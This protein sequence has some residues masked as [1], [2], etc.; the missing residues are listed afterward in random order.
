MEKRMT[1]QQIELLL[2]TLEKRLIHLEEIVYGHSASPPT[3][4]VKNVAVGGQELLLALANDELPAAIPSG[5]EIGSAPHQPVTGTGNG[6][7]FRD[8]EKYLAWTGDKR[9]P[10]KEPVEPAT[11]KPPSPSTTV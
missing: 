1:S 11:G 5:P 7:T 4:P 6:S 9:L 10:K 3:V 2:L 8:M